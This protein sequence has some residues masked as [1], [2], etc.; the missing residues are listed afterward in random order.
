MFFICDAAKIK[1][2]LFPDGGI[3]VGEI[4]QAIRFG[5]LIGF[6]DHF[7]HFLRALTAALDELGVDGSAGCPAP[8]EPPEQAMS[9]RQ[10]LFAPRE[11]IPLA[12]SEGRIAACQMAPY[13]PGVPVIAPGER[14]QKKHLVY[15]QKI[16]YNDDV[17]QVISES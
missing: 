4:P 1:D 7:H 14:I 10:A 17:C 12:Q 16:V 6:A 8:P 3:E 13:P 2:S 11:E 15:L 9:P 5:N